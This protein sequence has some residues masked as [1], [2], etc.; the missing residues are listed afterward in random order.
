MTQS[1][2]QGWIPL[3]HRKDQSQRSC[4]SPCL[5]CK[6]EGNPLSK[7][8]G[9]RTCVRSIA[10]KALSTGV[11]YGIV[12]RASSKYRCFVCAAI[13]SGVGFKAV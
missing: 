2:P 1:Q 5:A 9:L 13:S 10:C 4:R 11:G 12:W 8:S 6:A 7:A 3:G